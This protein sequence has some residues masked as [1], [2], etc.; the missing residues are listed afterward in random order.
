MIEPSSQSSYVSSQTRAVNPTGRLTFQNVVFVEFLSEMAGG[1]FPL[2]V[3]G[4]F[5]SWEIKPKRAG[6]RSLEEKYKQKGDTTQSRGYQQKG[7]NESKVK[8]IQ[9]LCLHC[10]VSNS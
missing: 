7:Q 1:S 10:I 6:G 5:D 2:V 3:I 4:L 8:E 9:M